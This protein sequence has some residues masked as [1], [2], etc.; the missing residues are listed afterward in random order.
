MIQGDLRIYNMLWKYPYYIRFIKNPTEEMK[1]IA[2]YKNPYLIRF[3]KDKTERIQL[4][5]VQQRLLPDV[6][7]YIKNP[8]I[9]V[10]KAAI[11]QFSHAIIHI[12]NPTEEIKEYALE[13]NYYLVMSNVM[14]EDKDRNKEFII[15]KLAYDPSIIHQMKDAEIDE[16]ILMELSLRNPSY[17]VGK[18]WW[19]KS[20]DVKKFVLTDDMIIAIAK[21]DAKLLNAYNIP[22]SAQ[23]KLWDINPKMFVNFHVKEEIIAEHY[24]EVDT[25]ELARAFF[26]QTKDT[27]IKVYL[28][29]AFGLIY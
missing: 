12:K 15:K 20:K 27:D 8:S 5:S 13:R 1:E 16:D 10:Q 9:D 28:S 18:D 25:E 21:K 6:I 11:D 2:C 23:E 19:S 22:L 7:A 3:I 14:L 29:L 26:S 17:V 4:F 24:A